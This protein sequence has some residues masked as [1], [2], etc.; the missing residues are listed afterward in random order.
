MYCT[1]SLSSAHWVSLNYEK[2]LKGGEESEKEHKDYK[3][4]QK[5]PNLT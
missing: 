3:K 4:E 2:E 1:F 5:E